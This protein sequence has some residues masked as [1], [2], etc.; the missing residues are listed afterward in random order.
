MIRSAS[1]R[2]C[3]SVSGGSPA[4]GTSGG[5]AHATCGSNGTA[6]K[7]P[8]CARNTRRVRASIRHHPTMHSGESD[9]EGRWDDIAHSEP[10]L[11][12]AAEAAVVR[13]AWSGRFDDWHDP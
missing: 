10:S 12:E 5:A 6:A 11:R 4:T 9:V 3:T 1:A 8:A 2:Y 13:R 7:A